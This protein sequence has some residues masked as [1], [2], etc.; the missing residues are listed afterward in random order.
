MQHGKRPHSKRCKTA[1]MPRTP[2]TSNDSCA[3]RFYKN[4]TA[5]RKRSP[6]A[7]R[8]CH[9]AAAAAAAAA[10]QRKALLRGA[11]GGRVRE[12]A[13]DEGRRAPRRRARRVVPTG[14]A[15]LPH[16]SKKRRSSA[17]ARRRAG[18]GRGVPQQRQHDARL[19]GAR[20][21]ARPPRRREHRH[22]PPLRRRAAAAPP[23]SSGVDE[24]RLALSGAFLAR[25]QPPGASARRRALESKPRC[26]W[27]LHV[28]EY[29]VETYEH[30]TL[31]YLSDHGSDF[32]GGRFVFYDGG[33]VDATSSRPRDGHLLPR[34]RDQPARRREGIF[35]LPFC[36][37]GPV[38]RE[39]SDPGPLFEAAAAAATPTRPG[40]RCCG[41]RPR[42][43]SWRKMPG[44]ATYWTTR[45]RR[46]S[47]RASRRT[48]GRLVRRA[49]GL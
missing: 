27:N 36:A 45:R 41:P 39:S 10:D 9:P 35:W 18:H 24:R 14:P 25:L 4:G 17:R 31:L 43:R 34:R 13:A 3:S 16:P 12:T 30:T 23:I 44:A 40:T 2:A 37:D 42:R 20:R 32:R 33:G 19:R 11:G 7:A 47:R 49:R 1:R 38:P 22:D 21:A 26:Y 46:P 5:P 6:A 48:C 15:R 8:R 28:D 29:N